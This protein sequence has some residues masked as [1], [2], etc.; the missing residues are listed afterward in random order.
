MPQFGYQLKEAFF[1]SYQQLHAGKVKLNGL[2]GIRHHLL[3]RDRVKTNPDID[4]TRSH[5]NHSIENLSPQNLISDVRLRIK[6]LNLKRKTRT[7]AVG[8]EDIIVG[9]SADFMLK[10][11]AD[12]REQYFKDALHFFQHKYGKENV[13]YCHC[14]LDESNPHIHIGIIPVTPDGRLSARDVFNPKSLEKLQTNFHREVSQ[15]YGLERGEHHSRNYLEL[16]QF[17]AQKAKQELIQ[18]TNDI[19][20]ARLTQDNIDKI[21]SNAHFSSSGFIFKSEDKNNTELPTT[22]FTKL[23]QISQDGAKAMALN[24]L[25]LEQNKQLQREKDIAQDNCDFLQH[26]LNLLEAETKHYTDV[27]ELWREH[28]DSSIDFWQQTFSTYCH[29]VNRATLRVFLA[30]HGNYKQT[31]KIMHDFIKKTDTN[32]VQKY[33][34]NVIYSAILQHKKNFQPTNKPPSWKKPKPNDTNYSKPDELGIVPLQLSHVPDID[35]DLINWDLLS[36]LEKD[37]IRNKIVAYSR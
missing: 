36:D 7:D 17:K 23:H 22:D 25:L 14:H 27:P 20:S 15:H 1:M 10:L 21:Y 33:V 29:D 13:V 8:L 31:E 9:A 11:G 34:A 5:L 30:S 3:D 37:E 6:Q 12:K 4:L 19:N 18:Y 26:Q 35:W 2:A 32:N 28:V 24:H 16:N